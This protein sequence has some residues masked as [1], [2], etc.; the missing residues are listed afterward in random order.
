MAEAARLASPR[1]LRA[2]TYETLLGLLS[3]TGLRPGEALS[4]DR[5]DVDLRGGIL[6]IRQTKFGKSRFVPVDESTRSA[7]ARYAERRDDLCPRYRTAAFL[8]SE[9]GSRLEGCA[10]RRTFAKISRS[11]GLRV[12]VGGRRVGRGPRLQD[13]RHSFT[14]CR[15]LEWYQAGLDVQRELPKLATYL[16]HS[17]VAH[18]YWYIQAVPELLLLA[19]ERL[20][21]PRQAGGGR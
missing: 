3:A 11:I 7:L 14:T 6:A 2:L 16:G 19:A 5:C 8:I 20:G 13:F 1:G 21:S 10:V 15:L 12:A 4:L 9:D 18:T 17:D